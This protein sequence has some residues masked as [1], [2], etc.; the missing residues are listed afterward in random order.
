MMNLL[1]FLAV[2]LLIA[3]A[4]AKGSHN[5]T[6][7]L[8]LGATCTSIDGQDVDC[9][10]TPEFDRRIIKMLQELNKR[11]HAITIPRKPALGSGVDVCADLSPYTP[12]FCQCTDNADGAGNLNIYIYLI[13][14]IQ[15][16]A[17]C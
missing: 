1:F 16:N 8:P 13:L 2:A 12:S 15:R 5:A 11:M 3:S 7:V 6:V 10:R 4:T 17:I 9:K 14:I